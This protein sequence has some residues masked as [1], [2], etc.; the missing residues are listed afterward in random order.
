M[1]DSFIKDLKKLKQMKPGLSS[2]LLFGFVAL[3]GIVI[4]RIGIKQKRQSDIVIGAII[5]IGSLFIYF[6]EFF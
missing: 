1:F 2:A 3:I 5:T 4:I 6:L